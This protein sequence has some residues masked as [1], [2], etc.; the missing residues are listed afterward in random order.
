M[1]LLV[2]FFQNFKGQN[3]WPILQGVTFCATNTRN[4]SLG[5]KEQRQQ[6]EYMFRPAVMIK[7]QET[8]RLTGCKQ[9]K[10]QKSKPDFSPGTK[11]H[12]CL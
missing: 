8:Q 1:I 5:S 6:T 4:K 10:Q 11:L 12:R 9:E 7:E 3:M 2:L